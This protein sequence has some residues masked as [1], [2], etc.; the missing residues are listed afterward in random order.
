MLEPSPEL[1]EAMRERTESG[2]RLDTVVLQLQVRTR[3][4]AQIHVW[5]GRTVV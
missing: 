2:R 4:T 1:E 5:W 3:A